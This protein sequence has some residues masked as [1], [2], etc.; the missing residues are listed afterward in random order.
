[1]SFRELSVGVLSNSVG[2][3]CVEVLSD[4]VVDPLLVVEVSGSDATSV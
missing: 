3:L 1:M 2:T 4:S